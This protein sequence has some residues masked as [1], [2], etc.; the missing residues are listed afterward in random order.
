MYSLILFVCYACM[1]TRGRK[2]RHSSEISLQLSSLG[3]KKDR[4]KKSYISTESSPRVRVL[5][6]MRNTFI[7]IINAAERK[8]VKQV[9]S[10]IIIYERAQ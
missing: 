9:L 3:K 7:S 4:K 8:D 1:Y 6:V 5:D 2:E 10:T